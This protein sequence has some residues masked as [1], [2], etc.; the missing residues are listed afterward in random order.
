MVTLQRDKRKMFYA[1]YSAKIPV[2]K[3]Y[4]DN[5]GNEYTIETGETKAGYFDPVE[6]FASISFG[7]GEVEA[8]EF[9]LSVADYDAL[10]LTARGTYPIDEKSRIW[11]ET[12]P[13]FKNGSVDGNTADFEVKAVKNSINYTKYLVKRRTK[14]K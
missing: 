5:E 11:L 4:K 8:Q 10:I 7:S 6:M 14:N 9:G 13:V 2:V 1:L 12:E 3:T